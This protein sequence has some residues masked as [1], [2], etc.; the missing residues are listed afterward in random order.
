MYASVA[1]NPAT[2]TDAN[3]LEGVQENLQPF[4][5][6]GFFKMWNTIMTIY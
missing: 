2:V 4:A 6:K 1:W 3:K 5:T